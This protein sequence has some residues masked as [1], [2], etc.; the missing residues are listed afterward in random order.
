L[1]GLGTKLA[2]FIFSDSQSQILLPFIGMENDMKN[3]IFICAFVFALALEI[4]DI[5]TSDAMTVGIIAMA[6]TL[7]TFL[8]D[9]KTKQKHIISMIG[10]SVFALVALGHSKL[11]NAGLLDVSEETYL[12]L[13][14]LVACVCL[15]NSFRDMVG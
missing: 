2:H 3:V 14:V 6:A 13:V 5:S 11:I 1:T 12:M 9:S 8:I 7:I 10:F 15:T 4:F